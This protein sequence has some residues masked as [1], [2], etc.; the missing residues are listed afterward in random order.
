MP[1]TL[2]LQPTGQVLTVPT[3]WYDVTLATF[4]ALQV[5]EPDDERRVAEV[6]L[7]LEAGG[8]DQL[9]ADDVAYFANLLAFA[10]DPAD[11]YA[12]LP[13]PG[14]PEVGSLPYGTLLMAQQRFAE[15]PERPW[16]ASAAY[17]LALYR[18]QLTYG[19]YDSAKVAACEAALLAAPV[20]EVYPDAAFFLSSY[21][22][23]SSG[24]GPTKT[25]T[26]SP[27]TKKSKR[28]MSKFLSGLGLS[29]GWTPRPGAAS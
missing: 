28:G 14:L 25:T 5:P 18:T 7:G 20:T 3:S 9:A 12:L 8:L 23:Y 16:L 24:T 29:L 19:K 1:I 22:R 13:T 4:L 15:V 11:L 26:S 27:A 21:R 2:T 17:L 10:T 6:L